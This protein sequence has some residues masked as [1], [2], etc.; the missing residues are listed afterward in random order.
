MPHK[1]YESI[2]FAALGGPVAPWMFVQL[3]SMG[4]FRLTSMAVL[5]E[6]PYRYRALHTRLET[7]L[8]EHVDDN[9][10]SRSLQRLTKIG[11]VRADS[12][13]FGSRVIKTYSLA[14][15]GESYLATYE[16]LACVLAHLDMSSDECDGVC[17]VHDGLCAKRAA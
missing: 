8:G 6:R 14:D 9:A 5:A 15:K 17:P 12:K 11:A 13:R 10:V 4:G 16:A 3:A 1:A 7:H 2:S